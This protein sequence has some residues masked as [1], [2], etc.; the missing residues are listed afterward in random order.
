MAIRSRRVLLTLLLCTLLGTAN[1]LFR[2][3]AAQLSSASNVEGDI[4]A[5]HND[6]HGVDSAPPGLAEIQH[7][8]YLYNTTEMQK[9]LR[10]PSEREMSDYYGAVWSMYEA[11]AS[12]PL[13]TTNPNEAT[14]FIP[15]LFPNMVDPHE[16]AGG[17]GRKRFLKLLDLT[18]SSPI[19]QATLGSRHIFGP[20]IDGVHFSWKGANTFAG[21]ILRYRPQWIQEANASS[22]WWN[23][24]ACTFEKKAKLQCNPRT[25][26]FHNA[27]LARDRD[28]WELHRMD[29]DGHN[30]RE[31]TV[32]LRHNDP[33]MAYGFSVGLMEGPQGV[34]LRPATYEK[35]AEAEW[36]FFYHTRPLPSACNSTVFR[37]APIVRPPIDG[38][39]EADTYNSS[40]IGF[41]IDPKDWNYRY[42]R[43]KFCL[44][45]RGDNP[46]SRALLRS[47]RVGCLPMVVSD[48]YPRYAPSYKSTLNM[49]DYA[50]L[51][52]E[53][54]FVADP[55]GELHRIYAE[56]TEAEVRRRMTA[57]AMAQRVIFPDHPRSLF[58]EAYLRE[59]WEAIPESERGVGCNGDCGGAVVE[60]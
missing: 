56:M 20:A 47:I 32:Q 25:I 7:R 27:I 14:F 22:P 33:M 24:T 4:P 36:T 44:V 35:F 6:D 60:R 5:I 43:S 55:W 49:T 50:I 30:Y 42:P 38:T 29:Q 23:V 2:S 16:R 19:Y 12:H 58:V 3:L 13:R 39:P 8:Y 28:M 59:A 51:V 17:R 34:E 46:I 45:V 53:Q 48:L 1:E 31:W 9:L 15:P 52:D 40:S 54:A 26:V 41:D 57:L 21:D 10:P 11:L 37:H 18:T